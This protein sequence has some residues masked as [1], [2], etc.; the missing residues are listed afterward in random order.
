MKPA[1]GSSFA[2]TTL[3]LFEL[4]K[5]TEFTLFELYLFSIT[6][7]ATELNRLSVRI[8]CWFWNSGVM[9]DTNGG[10]TSA[11]KNCL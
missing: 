9:C 10:R 1:S 6:A 11:P 7:W 5:S 3:Y 2:F 8:Y 4:C